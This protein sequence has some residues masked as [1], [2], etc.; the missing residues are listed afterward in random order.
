M[1]SSSARRTFLSMSI[2]TFKVPPVA[3]NSHPRAKPRVDVLEKQSR[4]TS[5]SPCNMGHVTSVDVVEVA[6]TLEHAT[7]VEVKFLHS[8]VSI[9]KSSRSQDAPFLMV[10]TVA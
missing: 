3:V 4:Q 9:E 7:I 2:K 8:G 10:P 1:L 6:V 5:F